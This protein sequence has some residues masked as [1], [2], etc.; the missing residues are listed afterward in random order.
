M[1][2]LSDWRQATQSRSRK[3]RLF[4]VSWNLFSH[5]SVFDYM[6]LSGVDSAT[7][8]MGSVES[9][10]LDAILSFLGSQR[11]VIIALSSA[12]EHKSSMARSLHVTRLT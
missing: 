2:S 7:R 5:Q 3:P 1:E 11:A 9:T 10:Y 12:T 4:D 6:R 8:L